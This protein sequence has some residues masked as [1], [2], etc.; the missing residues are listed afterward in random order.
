MTRLN[1]FIEFSHTYYKEVFYYR[2]NDR[3]GFV[4]FYL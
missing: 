4:L 1:H 2:V 3:I